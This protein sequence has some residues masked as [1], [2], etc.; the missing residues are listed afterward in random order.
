MSRGVCL[1][2]IP[3]RHLGW[4]ARFYNSVRDLSPFDRVVT[5]VSHVSGCRTNSRVPVSSPAC[6]ETPMP[7]EM[8][9]D[10]AF[11]QVHGSP[12]R[13]VS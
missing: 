4:V 9:F 6:L 12:S 5:I 7:R 10:P 2:L 3:T 11:L 1:S 8:T 13:Q